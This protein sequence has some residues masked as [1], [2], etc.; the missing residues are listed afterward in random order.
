VA[1][2]VSIIAQLALRSVKETA[3]FQRIEIWEWQFSFA[4]FEFSTHI[5]RS[6]T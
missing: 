6:Q 3:G 2:W 1:M 5:W 4:G